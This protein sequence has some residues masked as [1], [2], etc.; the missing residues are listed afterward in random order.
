M[1]FLNIWGSRFCYDDLNPFFPKPTSIHSSPEGNCP[2]SQCLLVPSVKHSLI[3]NPKWRSSSNDPV[4]VARERSWAWQVKWGM[5]C[6]LRD[7]EARSKPG[8]QANRPLPLPAVLDCISPIAV[9]TWIQVKSYPWSSTSMNRLCPLPS[10]ARWTL[11]N[12]GATA[13]NNKT[14]DVNKFSEFPHEASWVC[15]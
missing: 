14:E 6:L 11:P 15:L 12:C 10:P 4:W 3:S 9:F 8:Y 13:F 5:A 7:K 1:K 2:F